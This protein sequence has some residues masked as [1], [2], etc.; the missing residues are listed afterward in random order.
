M[1]TLAVKRQ[2]PHRHG[3]TILNRENSVHSTSED[4]KLSLHEPPDERQKSL[5]PN[6]GESK[7]V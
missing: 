5:T 6:G 1:D 4:D 2:T 7:R 3:I